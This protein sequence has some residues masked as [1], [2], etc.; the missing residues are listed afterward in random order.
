V[1]ILNI[2]KKQLQKK[3][4]KTIDI[5]RFSG[6]LGGIPLRNYSQNNCIELQ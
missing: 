3:Y 5:P 6:I 1:L 4:F 2:Q